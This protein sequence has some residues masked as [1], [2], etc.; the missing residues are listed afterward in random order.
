MEILSATN[1]T[2]GQLLQN[3]QQANH[4]RE[5]PEMEWLFELLHSEIGEA[6]LS[7]TLDLIDKLRRLNPEIEYLLAAILFTLCPDE[8]D[9]S[10]IIESVVPEQVLSL[11]QRLVR[12]FHLNPSL[13]N[14]EQSEK[15][16]KMLITLTGDLQLLSIILAI[17]LQKMTQVGQLPAVE[18]Q[19]LAQKTLRIYTPLANRLGIFWIKSELED[20]ALFYIEPDM[21]QELKSKVAK[22]RHDRAQIVNDITGEIHHL[23]E[24][25]EIPHEVYGRSKH[26]YSIFK[27]LKKVDQN[28]DRIQDLIGFRVLTHSVQDCYAA[29]SYI[30]ERWQSKPNRFKDYISKPKPN[31]Y[32][33]LHTTV[34]TP[35]GEPIEIQIRTYE[36]H[37]VAEY[38]I[39]AHWLYK[40]RTRLTPKE[41]E[42]YSNLSQTNHGASESP[43]LQQPQIDLFSDRIYVM[44]PNRDI[45]E[46]PKG[47][48]AVDFAYAIHTEVG[49]HVIGAKT[50]GRIVKLDDTLKSGDQVEVLTSPRQNPHKEWLTFVKTSKAKNKIRHAVHEQTREHNRKTGWEL[51]DKEFKKHNL[52]LNRMVKEGKL[53]QSSQEHKNQTFEH[54]LFCLGEGTVRINEV[55]R[56]FVVIE[57]EEPAAPQKSSDSS[58]RRKGHISP[59]NPVIVDGMTNMLT[60]FAKCCAPEKGDAILGYITQGRGITVHRQEC[61]S[62]KKMDSSR[63]ISIHW[64]LKQE[65]AKD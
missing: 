20:K 59:T 36:M 9:I 27:K 1:H 15:A 50:N 4:K 54:I 52:N 48:T 6:D 2:E 47:A 63:F 56:W 46:L 16:L 34:L 33:S 43:L 24:K 17:W 23:L 51:L 19:N 41:Q 49:H 45:V 26:F 60:R 28:F 13:R 57:E 10:R 8:E 30:H 32:R 39:A 5:L 40:E 22:K 14:E 44:T 21:Y 3:I 53:E 35:T 7:Q 31:G 42:L 65:E 62:L 58:S 38:G 55:V 61:S 64:N 37:A 12:T 25:S 18:Q 29:L 11:H